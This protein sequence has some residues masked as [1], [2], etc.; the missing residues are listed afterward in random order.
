MKGG[1]RNWYETAEIR[2]KPSAVFTCEM[3][4]PVAKNLFDDGIRWIRGG[5]GLQKEETLF[6]GDSR[7]DALA[8]KAAGLTSVLIPSGYGIWAPEELGADHLLEKFSD[9]TALV[10]R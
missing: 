10:L 5:L 3:Y 9:L 1:M 6:I 8:A 2:N 4:P 7:N